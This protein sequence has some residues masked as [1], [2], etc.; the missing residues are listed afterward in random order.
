MEL[1][2][3]GTGGSRERLIAQALGVNVDVDELEVRA[4]SETSARLP[5]PFED[6]QVGVKKKDRGKKKSGYARNKN[7]PG[8]G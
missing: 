1:H 5:T 8:R 7:R 3:G 6:E 2:G 4:A